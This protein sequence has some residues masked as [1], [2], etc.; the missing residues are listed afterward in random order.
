M[1]EIHEQSSCEPVHAARARRGG[2]PGTHAVGREPRHP[3]AGGGTGGS[4]VRPRRS[5]GGAHGIGADGAGEARA[6]LEHVE[7]LLAVGR[8]SRSR[9]GCA[10]PWCPARRS[11]VSAA[12]VRLRRR[13][14]RIAVDLLEGADQE[15]RRWCD[16]GLVDL[17][18]GAAR[19]LQPAVPLLSDEMHLV[20]PAGHPLEGAPRVAP[21]SLRGMPF[22]MSASG[23]EPTIQE[24]ARA[25]DAE[26]EVALRVRDT[27]SLLAMV[28]EEKGVTV[29]PE[30]SL[31]ADRVDGPAVRSFTPPL[32]RR[33]WL[34]P[35]RAED[36]PAGV[37]DQVGAAHR[38][39]VERGS[40]ACVSQERRGGTAAPLR[41]VCVR[42]CGQA[43]ERGPHPDGTAPRASP[44]RVPPSRRAPS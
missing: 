14:P 5:R 28:R 29:L 36:T 37:A 1:V 44:R 6:A 16:E 2:A 20:V 34:L 30:L 27:R 41:T 18:V 39:M 13:H 23:C 26:L 15:V 19:R 35:G 3:R 21:A 9:G 42:A 12:L 22:V 10:W 4:A 43:A 17:G 32:P 25:A 31:A 38:A 24:A 7:R 11:R 8:A 33:L 40:V